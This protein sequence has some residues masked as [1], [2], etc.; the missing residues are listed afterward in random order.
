MRQVPF[1]VGAQSF[2]PALTYKGQAAYLS[3]RFRFLMDEVGSA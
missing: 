2:M 3:I 1:V